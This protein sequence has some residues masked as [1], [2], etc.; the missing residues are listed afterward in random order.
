MVPL[1][2][3]LQHAHFAIGL[4]HRLPPTLRFRGQQDCLF[5]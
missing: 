2:K 3:Q 5:R 4:D 1:I